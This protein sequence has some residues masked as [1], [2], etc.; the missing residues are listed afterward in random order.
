MK[1]LTSLV[2][3]GSPVHDEYKSS[4]VKYSKK[5]KSLHQ[6]QVIDSVRRSF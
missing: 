1:M 2:S 5:H 6:S 3:E 4:G